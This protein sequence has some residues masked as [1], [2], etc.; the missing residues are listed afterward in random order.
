MKRQLVAIMSAYVLFWGLAQAQSI[1]VSVP[2]LSLW[3]NSGIYVTNGEAITINANG[4]WSTGGAVNGISDMVF[5]TQNTPDG[6]LYDGGDVFMTDGLLGNLIA[7]LGD[8]PTV[9][10]PT[11]FYDQTEYFAIG[12]SRQLVANT[13]GWLWLGLNDDSD[14]GSVTDNDGA[15]NAQIF[16]GYGATNSDW[17]DTR[18][19]VAVTSVSSNNFAFS[20][21]DTNYPN[22]FWAVYDSS[23]LKN[24]VLVG[25]VTLDDSGSG[26]FSNTTGVP[27]RFYKVCNGQTV[28]RVIGFEQITCVPGYTAIANQLDVTSDQSSSDD[29]VTPVFA[30]TASAI[31]DGT[32][33]CKQT[34]A[35][36]GYYPA[37]DTWSSSSGSWSDSTVTLAPGEG[38]FILT[39]TNSEPFNIIFAGYVREGQLSRS[40]F[41]NSSTPANSCNLMGSTIPL[42]G[43]I[44]SNLN[45][46]PNS[47][48][49]FYK[50]IPAAQGWQAAWTYYNSADAT[51]AFSVDSTIFP[52][53]WYLYDGTL[54]EPIVQVGEGFVIWAAASGT[55][56]QTFNVSP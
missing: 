28:S 15:V 37:V 30:W 46:S 2:A 32:Q 35:G 52:A 54:Q 14:G 31:P 42:A 49:N 3:V 6:A 10:W 53:G 25:A 56:S 16:V 20:I 11:N 7:Y 38:G 45:Y 47:G 55:W 50:W 8:S 39:P 23:D 36:E 9:G 26:S 29:T 24:W 41:H 5:G 22:S 1:T 44:T 13:N 43:K 51:A 12:S 27:Y 48:D 33:I 34:T 4:N 40:I 17:P 19:I 21:T 18:P